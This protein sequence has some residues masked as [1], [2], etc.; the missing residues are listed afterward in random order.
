MSSSGMAYALAVHRDISA[1]G[2]GANGVSWRRSGSGDGIAAKTLWRC[3]A[4][5]RWRIA[6]CR[7]VEKKRKQTP[8]IAKV[9]GNSAS[10]W[11]RSIARRA[12]I[13]RRKRYRNS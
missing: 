12:G 6:A 11:L 2:A 5:A 10:K 8:G 13:A 7:C 9:G 4:L 3:C 1:A